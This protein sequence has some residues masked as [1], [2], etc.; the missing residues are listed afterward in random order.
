[1]KQL[2]I[3][4]ALIFKLSCV[5]AQVWVKGKCDTTAWTHIDTL[6]KYSDSAG[7]VY[8]PW[9]VIPA[10]IP[11]SAHRRYLFDEQFRIGKSSGWLM[12]RERR[13]E[14]LFVPAEKTQYEKII[15]SVSK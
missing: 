1:M 11:D 3:I 10:S 4:A 9:H 2:T 8:S 14:L 12:R 13:V 6:H 15:D 7:W 5:Q